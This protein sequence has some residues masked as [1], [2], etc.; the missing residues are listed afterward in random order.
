MCLRSWPTLHPAASAYPAPT[1]ITISHGISRKKSFQVIIG[2]KGSSSSSSLSSSQAA[3]M[4]KKTKSTNQMDLWPSEWG[5]GECERTQWTLTC[6]S[7]R[8]WRRPGLACRDE[9]EEEAEQHRDCS[10]GPVAFPECRMQNGAQ[11]SKIFIQ[12]MLE[13]SLFVLDSRHTVRFSLLV[14]VHC[15]LVFVSLKRFINSMYEYR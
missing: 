7:A 8:R 14:L 5:C 6:A 12:V 2:A 1:R 9:E 4:Q 10:V 3:T 11:I 15:F 13:V